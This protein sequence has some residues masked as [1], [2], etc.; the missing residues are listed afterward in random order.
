MS[1]TPFTNLFTNDFPSA[2]PNQIFSNDMLG[3]EYDF[4][5]SLETPNALS[6]TPEMSISSNDYAQPAPH[7]LYSLNIPGQ[8]T[9]L[10][11]NLET[12]SYEPSSS[13]E[14]SFSSTSTPE[15]PQP[16]RDLRRPKTKTQRGI[17]NQPPRQSSNTPNHPTTTIHPRTSHLFPLQPPLSILTQRQPHLTRPPPL[18]ALPPNLQATRRRQTARESAYS[19]PETFSLLAGR[20]REEGMEGLLSE[21]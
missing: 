2:N 19:Q 13:Q 9:D 16:E 7:D 4:P 1:Q 10:S 17:R 18:P 21:G 12:N 15:Q 6:T 14:T 5:H 3:Q 8:E 11:N 20:V